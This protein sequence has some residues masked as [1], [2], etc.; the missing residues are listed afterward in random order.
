MKFKIDEQTKLL[1][2]LSELQARFERCNSY[3]EM[4]DMMTDFVYEYPFIPES[5]AAL[6]EIKNM[7][8]P[9]ISTIASK[10]LK[11]WNLIQEWRQ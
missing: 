11:N 9:G 1:Y 2:A 6:K 3:D 4:D 7:D 5:K 10:Y 8:I